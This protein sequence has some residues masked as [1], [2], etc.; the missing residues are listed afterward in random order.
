MSNDAPL[1][2]KDLIAMGWK[3]GPVF[4][5]ALEAARGL[6]RDAALKAVR[7][8]QARAEAA[9]ARAEAARAERLAKSLPLQ[10]GVPFRINVRPE[11][12]AEA[13]NLA[14]VV[15]G[16]RGLVRTP[17]VVAAALMPDTCP[18]GAPNEIP[19]GG[20]VA[21]RGAIHPG[22]HSADICCSM[23]VT[24]LQGRDPKDVLD[25]GAKVTHFGPGGRRDGRFSPP[26]HLLAAFAR[27]PFLKDAKLLAA[28][29]S[30]FATQGDGNH[31]FY[32][33]T[34]ADGESTIVTHHG[35][36]G[37]GAMLY[38]AGLEVAERFRQELSPE[39]DPVNAWIPT[40]SR[41][42]E[43]YWEALQLVREWTR[44][45][46]QA[47]H[48][49]VAE[50]LRAT[51]TDRLWNEHNFVF[52]EDDVI[53]HAKGSTPIHAPFLPDTDGR[54]IV[55]L[56][57]AQPVLIVRG[58]RNDRNLGFAPHGA[59]R[60]MSRTAH[61]KLYPKDM[62]DEE[63]VRLETAGIDARFFC[64]DVDVTELP[65]AYKDAASVRRDME[66]FGLCE[67][68]EEIAP[69][70]CVMGGDFEKNAPWK[71]KRAEKLAAREAAALEDDEESPSP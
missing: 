58:T 35:S 56:N 37:V 38:K 8:V 9:Q 25:A 18:A 31:F 69:Y 10:D 51:I 30:N 63:I 42:G 7:V 39:T 4:A 14:A 5:E 6:D 13:E 67:V 54:Q 20:V 43:A 1:T 47:I 33:G 57:M 66:H 68:V 44:L 21:A 53:W 11:N 19:V 40:A 46:H 22:M 60:N 59:G 70:G 62:P 65:S 27:N 49:A 29:H 28:A 45:S 34:G 61:R 16:F 15:R 64:P 3:P 71:R 2:G 24:R 32:V 36:R 41:E 55:P 52:R 17:T 26:A 48:D 23:F 12:P 50:E